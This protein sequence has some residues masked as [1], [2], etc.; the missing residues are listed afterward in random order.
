[1]PISIGSKKDVVG[2][3]EAGAQGEPSPKERCRPQGFAA[4]SPEAHREIARSGGRTAHERGTAHEFTSEEARAAGRKGGVS[5]SVD[6]EH[7]SKIGRAGGL[8]RWQK[9]RASATEPVT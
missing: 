4:L 9:A 3:R 1:M 7:M 2:D 6:R 8:R 5:V